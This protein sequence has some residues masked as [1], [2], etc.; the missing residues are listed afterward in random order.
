MQDDDMCALFNLADKGGGIL[1]FKLCL[2]SIH[3][4]DLKRLRNDY[5]S[6][7]TVNLVYMFSL[8]I[9]HTIMIAVTINVST[10][11]NV[12]AKNI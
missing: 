10:A 9:F 11:M 5:K 3:V 12:S 1:H 6:K 4:S 7:Q 2:V 8:T